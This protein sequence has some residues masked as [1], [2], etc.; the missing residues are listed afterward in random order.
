MW[1]KRAA[2]NRL[3][4][5]YARCRS[6]DGRAAIAHMCAG[7]WTFERSRSVGGAA[8]AGECEQPALKVALSLL[9]HHYSLALMAALRPH[10]PVRT[11]VPST[12]VRH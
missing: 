9:V 6:R 2:G 10:F 3:A 1:P 11:A 8:G 12:F 7:N 5:Q 4:R